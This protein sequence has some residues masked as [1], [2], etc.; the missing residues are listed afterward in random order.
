MWRSSRYGTAIRSSALICGATLVLAPSGFA[1]T[2]VTTQHN[3]AARSGANLS[4]T[5]LTPAN[6]NVGQ[7]GKLFERTVDDQVYAQPLYVSN[8]NVPTVGLRNVLYVATVSNSVYAF[9]ADNPA[10]TEPL[11]RVTYI[12]SPTVVPVHRTDVGQACGEYLD[13]SGNIGIVGTPVIDVAR[14]TIY[15]VARTKEN[16]VFVQRLHALDIRDGSERPNSPVN[17]QATS[18]RNGRRKR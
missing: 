16:G 1:Q 18:S 6:V 15:F 4:E 17:I 13:F 12:N 2:N 5:I 3:D 14:Q 9:D 8:V 10:A 7:F 11:W